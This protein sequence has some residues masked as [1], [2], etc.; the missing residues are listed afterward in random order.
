MATRF[1]DRS[2]TLVIAA[3]PRWPRRQRASSIHGGRIAPA[4]VHTVGGDGSNNYFIFKSAVISPSKSLLRYGC[5]CGV[6][7]STSIFDGCPF[8]FPLLLPAVASLFTY[9]LRSS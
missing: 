9:G 1:P 8:L 3:V 7:A 4:V 2:L 6:S 5:D